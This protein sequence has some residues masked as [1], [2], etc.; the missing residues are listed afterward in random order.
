MIRINFIQISNL[1]SALLNIIILLLVMPSYSQSAKD[2]NEI[3]DPSNYLNDIKIEFN[4]K[5]PKNRTIN[6]V[7]HGHSVPA[8]YYKAPIVKPFGAYPLMLL[9]KMKSFYPYAVIS[10]IN[11]SIGG[12]NSVSGANRFDSDVSVHKPDVLFIDYSLNDRGIGLEKAKEAWSSMIK[13]ALDKNIKII[14]LTPSPDTRKNILEVNNE[15]EQHANLVRILA[16]E[17][18]IGLVDSY[19]LFKNKVLAGDSLS[20]YMS[21]VVHPNEKGHQLITDELLKYFKP[22]DEEQQIDN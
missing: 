18:G 6:L 22:N 15:L 16:K 13:K 3:A 11:T 17:N 10:V 19:T 12:E 2:S 9:K 1:R 20:M 8:G 14:L 4:K 21:S 5:W 7:F